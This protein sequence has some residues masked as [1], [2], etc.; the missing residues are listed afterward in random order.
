[1]SALSQSSR[2][3]GNV[4]ARGYYVMEARRLPSGQRFTE[5]AT[6]RFENADEARQ[7]C[8]AMRDADPG[9]ALHCAEVVS[10]D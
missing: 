9:R 6:G 8:T 7:A 4:I 2:R 10:Y 3:A 1:M 5:Y